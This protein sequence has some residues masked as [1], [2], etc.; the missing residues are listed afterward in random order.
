[1]GGLV[2]RNWSDSS[3][4]DSYAEGSVTGSGS[5]GGLVGSHSFGSVANSYYDHNEVL[6][7]GKK[8][9]TVG[10]LLGEDFGQWL[11]N[12]KSLDVDDRLSQEHGYYLINNVSDLKELLAFGQDSSLRFRLASDLDLA[13]EVDFYIPYL[14][15]QFDGNG[16]RISD[17]NLSLDFVAQTGLF[18]VLASGGEIS[19]ISVVNAKVTGTEN[20]G[21]LVGRNDGTVSGSC[22][23]GSVIG[24]GSV[25][26]LVGVCSGAVRDSY[27]SG[28]V[29]GES[30]VGGLVALCFG[31]VNNSHYDYEELRINGKSI[32]TI[33][34]LSAGDFEQWLANDKFLDVNQRL[35]QDDSYYVINDV[36]DFRSLLAFGQDSTLRFRLNGDIDLGNDLNFYIPYLAGEFDGAGHIVANLSF[37]FDFVMQVGLFGYLHHS[38]RVAE[39]GVEGVNLT[40]SMNVGG[41]VG[42]NNGGSVSRSYSTGSVTGGDFVGGLIGVNRGN[43]NN[44][45]ST[46]NVSGDWAIGGLMGAIH[47]G[48]VSNSYSA[49]TVTGRSRVG[50]LAGELTSG[51]VSK[52]YSSGSV[53]GDSDVGGLLGINFHGTVSNSFWDVQTSGMEES[54]GGTGKTTAEMQSIGAF[55]GA[56][57]DITAV[58][59]PGVRNTAYIWN[60]V[61]GETY[62]FLSW[63]SVS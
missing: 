57:W 19:A 54:N 61:D 23:A 11:A 16:H 21:G 9:I 60:M 37:T 6:V 33:G 1:V 48:T 10:A 35:S 7:N 13:T 20:V 56:G 39:L 49:A 5:V 8:V 27:A 24:Y 53:T 62:P 34:A 59:N 25:G 22:F 44:S 26:G 29:T 55:S 52:C 30:G 47:G 41:L 12:G 51:T 3:V 46:C 36:S 43:A 31:T 38:A 63:E 15:G 50:G 32:I 2:G 40:G 17:L 18:G 45:Y 58:A 14:A 28:S 42:D 4:I